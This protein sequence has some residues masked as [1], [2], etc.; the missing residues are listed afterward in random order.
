VREC[1]KFQDNNSCPKLKDKIKGT[2]QIEKTWK[3]GIRSTLIKLVFK[4]I[5]MAYLFQNKLINLTN[6]KNIIINPK[7]IDHSC[8][9]KNCLRLLMQNRYKVNKNIDLKKYIRDKIY[10]QKFINRK[11][12]EI[13]DYDLEYLSLLGTSCFYC[14]INCIFGYSKNN[15]KNHPDTLTYDKKNPDIGYCKENIVPCCWF[16]NRMKNKSIYEDWIKLIDFLTNKDNYIL[17]LSNKNYILNSQ[18]INLCNIYYHIKKKSQKYYT[19]LNIAKNIFM[20]FLRDKYRR[21]IPFS[22]FSEDFYEYADNLV[23]KV[24]EKKDFSELILKYINLIPPKQAKVLML[25][26]V[27]KLTLSEICERLGKDMNYVKTTQKRA[28]RSLREYV[29]E[30]IEEVLN[31]K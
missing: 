29:A 14:N 24:E 17:D 8:C 11:Y 20:Q 5:W 4:N 15:E 21:E 25:R 7:S 2:I 3:F 31:V 19:S 26:L 16:C 6:C 23:T 27:D 22:N 18:K 9:S 28:I 10:K 12:N 1:L 13:L 30:N